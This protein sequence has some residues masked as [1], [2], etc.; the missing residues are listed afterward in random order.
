MEHVRSTEGCSVAGGGVPMRERLAMA[1]GPASYARYF[2]GQARVRETADGGLDVRVA[3]GFL[4]KALE[5]RFAAVLRDLVPTGAGVLFTVDATVREGATLWSDHDERDDCATLVLGAGTTSRTDRVRE[6]GGGAGRAMPSRDGGR[7]EA[8]RGGAGDEGVRDVAGSAGRDVARGRAPAG[9]GTREEESRGLARRGVADEGGPEA[10]RGGRAD[11]GAAGA[12]AGRS[13][14]AGAAAGVRGGT[15]GGASGG[16]ETITPRRSGG[17]PVRARATIAELTG[18]ASRQTFDALVVGASNQMAVAAARSVA[19]GETGLVVLHGPCGL[20][21]SHLLRAIAHEVVRTRPG[22]V[23]RCVSAEG[24]TNEF[25]QAVRANKVE[26][27]RK[28][29]RTCDLLCV[30]DVHF[31]ASKEATQQEL[32]HTLDAAAMSG[33]LVALACDEHPREV[34]RFSE[35]L[36]SRCMSGPVVRVE[37]PDAEMRGRLVRHIAARRGLALEDAAVALIADRGGHVGLRQLPAS[38]RDLEGMV[39]QIEAVRTLLPELS[40]DEDSG[41]ERRVGV[42]LVRKALGLT[43]GTPAARVARRPIQVS[44][45]MD[46]VCACVGAEAREVMGK[47][48]HQRIVLA[49]SLVAH[50]SRRLT[51]MSFPE[52]ARAM[53]RPNHSTIITAQKRLEREMAATDGGRLDWLHGPAGGLTLREL[54]EELAMRIRRD[55]SQQ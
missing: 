37:P 55:A 21:K 25:I 48:R 12:D 27:F 28:A 49:R 30:D 35:R 5:R 7:G 24:F 34:A 52:I 33:T 50:L 32:L 31:L 53:G 4:C 44:E 18:E 11:F 46:A 3:S 47:G 45:I 10:R 22:A 6:G 41:P 1:I 38:V 19:R 36:V 42:V 8:G 2:A 26:A 13:E 29:F 54:V 17:A 15:G 9:A 23:V 43:E 16:F 20:G 39:I 51:T 40:C 14:R